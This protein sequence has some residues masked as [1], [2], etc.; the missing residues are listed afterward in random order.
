MK[1]AFSHLLPGTCF[2]GAIAAGM[3]AGIAPTITKL[4]PS[5]GVPSFFLRPAEIQKMQK[6]LINL[7]HG[8]LK[9]DH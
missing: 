7:D 3:D 9:K 1:K 4:C 6:R 5:Q 8:L 2:S